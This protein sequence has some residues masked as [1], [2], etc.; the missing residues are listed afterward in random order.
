MNYV[1]NGKEA[2]YE[3]IFMV[4]GKK[5]NNPAQDNPE[6]DL[7]E[8]DLRDLQE[9]FSDEQKRAKTQKRYVFARFFC[10]LNARRLLL[11]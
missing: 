5:G 3:K 6:N 7:P 11:W 9:K 2:Y 10:M 8:A 1:G 4:G